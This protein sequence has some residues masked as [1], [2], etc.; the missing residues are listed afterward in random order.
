VFMSPFPLTDTT[1]EEEVADNDPPFPPINVGLARIRANRHERIPKAFQDGSLTIRRQYRP[2]GWE[3][4][5]RKGNPLEAGLGPHKNAT[6]FRS[7]R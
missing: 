2:L 5:R 7:E 6:A 3:P 1:P 4:G